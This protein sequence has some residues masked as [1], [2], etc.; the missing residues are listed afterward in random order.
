MVDKVI[1]RKPITITIMTTAATTIEPA[2]WTTAQ[3]LAFRFFMI[4]FTLYII[5]E[6]NGVL[7]FSDVLS[8]IYMAPFVHFIPWVGKNIL[9]LAQPVVVEQTGSGDTM[10]DYLLMLLMVTTA[11]FGMVVW[12]ALD[13]KTKN[14]NKLYYWLCVIV[15]YY[16]AITMVVY[17]GIKV[18]KLQFPAPSLGRML[19]PL[20]QMSPMGLAWTYM[21][22][23]KAFNWV[24]GLAE[25]SVG[26]LLFFRRTT[27]LGAIVGVFVIGNVMA[28][29]YC[30]DV[31]VKLLS[32]TMVVMCIFLMFRDYHRLVNFFFKNREAAPSN[33]SPHR[34]RSKEK[35]IALLVFK[36]LLIGYVLYSN[37]FMAFYYGSPD[38]GKKPPLY[39]VYKVE[40]FISGKDTLPPLTTDTTRWNILAIDNNANVKV[41]SDSTT[42]YLLNVD[43]V[44]KHLVI[45]R[46]KYIL[47][48]A[49]LKPD[50]IMLQGTWKNDSVQIKLVKQ[51]MSSSFPLVTRGFHWVMQQAYNR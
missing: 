30:F 51:P 16:V 50:T 44:H 15:R 45:S 11:A 40:T 41:C 35:N 4:F 22:Y 20:G 18:V 29:N 23:S 25:L 17:G 33:L 2:N 14:Y 49:I 6:P 39:G 43:T 38:D 34:F 13:R 1:F 47:R 7:P 9:H 46:H 27:T 12:T 21:G 28:V 24:T 48:Y 10:Y 36:C 19:E 26:L 31:P 5:M 3:K 42:G 32:T 37:V 8:T